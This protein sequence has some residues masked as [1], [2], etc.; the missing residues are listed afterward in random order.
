MNS[1]RKKNLLKSTALGVT[2]AI[3]SVSIGAAEEVTSQAK[4]QPTLSRMDRAFWGR[5][6]FR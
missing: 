2:L 3:G 1:F 5:S 4:K 6:S